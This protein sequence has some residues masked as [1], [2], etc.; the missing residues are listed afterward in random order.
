MHSFS[1]ADSTPR[2][3][4]SRPREMRGRCGAPTGASIPGWSRGWRFITGASRRPAR[5]DFCPWGRTSGD[6]EGARAP[7]AEAFAPASPML[8]QPLKAVGRSAHGRLPKAS[9]S[10]GSDATAAGAAPNGRSP[11]HLSV[12][13][14]SVPVAT[15]PLAGGDR[16]NLRE[17]RRAGIRFLKIL[18]SNWRGCVFRNRV[19]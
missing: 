7:Q 13:P 5:G 19:A 11:V 8:V 16:R 10:D 14:V 6:R 4:Q 12:R 1:R 18:R 15:R 3:R 2:H 17:A 9:R